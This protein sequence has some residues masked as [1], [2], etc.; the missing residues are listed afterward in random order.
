MK[1]YMFRIIAVLAVVIDLSLLTFMFYK[2]TEPFAWWAVMCLAIIEVTILAILWKFITRVDK[3]MNNR[4]PVP[5]NGDEE[6]ADDENDEDDDEEDDDDETE[7]QS[8]SDAIE[9][10]IETSTATY[11]EWKK[12]EKARDLQR[13]YDWH[14][15][16]RVKDKDEHDAIKDE[17]DKLNDECDE[18][19]AEIFE[20]DLKDIKNRFEEEYKQ[21]RES[22]RM[23]WY[24]AYTSLVEELPF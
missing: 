24:G 20:S 16:Y 1:K 17:I 3:M 15:G 22:L 11:P 18:T 5:Y 12:R 21:W 4:E 9:S 6:E 8:F 23:E 7:E 10:L 13:L 14:T 19:L 2:V